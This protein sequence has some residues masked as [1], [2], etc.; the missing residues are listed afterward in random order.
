MKNQNLIQQSSGD[1]ELFTELNEE[2][3]NSIDGGDFLGDVGK[4]ISD[5]YNKVSGG[6]KHFGQG[7]KDGKG[8]SPSRADD[9]WYN[10]GY[11]GPRFFGG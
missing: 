1:K 10:A 6:V 5:V 9:L 4:G 7:L 8:S 11:G 3:L 2:E